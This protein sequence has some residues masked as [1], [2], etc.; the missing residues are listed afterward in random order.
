MLKNVNEVLISDVKRSTFFT[1]VVD[2][3]NHLDSGCNI[4][5]HLDDGVYYLFFGNLSVVYKKKP[6][7]ITLKTLEKFTKVK[8]LILDDLGPDVMNKQQRT[9]FL[10]IVEERYLLTSTI[11]TSQLLL[12]QWYVVFD[13]PTIADAVFDRL[14][15]NAHKIVLKGDSM[16]KNRYKVDKNVTKSYG[17]TVS[18][19][20]LN[21]E[22]SEEP[23]SEK[24]SQFPI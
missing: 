19:N 13:E 1:I 14:F 7:A 22:R 23:R 8:L 6:W 4:H 2:I 21:S 15:H 11:I 17:Y 16:R 10:D 3:H 12:D 20:I 18:I 24:I 9:I 5:N